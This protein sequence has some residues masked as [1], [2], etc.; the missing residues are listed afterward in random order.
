MNKSN[1]SSLDIADYLSRGEYDW[2]PEAETRLKE[3]HD[4]IKVLELNYK[5]QLDIAEKQFAYI[6]ELEKTNVYAVNKLKEYVD[7]TQNNRH[8]L[9]DEEIVSLYKE[10]EADNGGIREFARAILRKVQ[11]K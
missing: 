1:Q 11:E 4:R 9:T 2:C 5:I 7:K 10:T 6:T 3:Q 8:E